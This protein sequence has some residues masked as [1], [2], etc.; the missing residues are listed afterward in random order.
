MSAMK[1]ALSEDA[2]GGEP[3]ERKHFVHRRV[4]R[5]IRLQQFVFGLPEDDF[6]YAIR[7]TDVDGRAESN[8]LITVGWMTWFGR[9]RGSDR[10]SSL[11]LA[12]LETTEAYSSNGSRLLWQ[13]VKCWFRRRVRGVGATRSV[14]VKEK[15]AS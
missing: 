12:L 7:I 3:L 15:L 8:A 11:A 4:E 10:Q 5:W 1:I 6:S 14:A 2:P 9:G 13:A